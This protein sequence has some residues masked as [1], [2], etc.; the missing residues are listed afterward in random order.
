[1]ESFFAP[2]DGKPA[3]KRDFILKR[4]N[5]VFLLLGTVSVQR[6]AGQAIRSR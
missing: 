6:A 3:A 5:V 2:S 1:M 4:P